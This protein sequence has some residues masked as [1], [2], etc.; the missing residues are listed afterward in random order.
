MRQ[1]LFDLTGRTALVTGAS[2]G[3]GREIALALA[4]AGAG[5]VLAA[6]RQDRLEEV[7]RQIE[8]SGGRADALVVDLSDPA[9]IEQM[10]ARCANAL[11]A[12]DILVNAAGVNPRTPVAQLDLQTWHDTLHI[13]L[14]VPF[15]LARSLTTAMCERG[16][17][18]IINLASLQSL[19]AFPDGLPYGTAKGG[20]VQMT[21]AMAQ[22]WSRFGVNCNAIGPGFFPTE[23]TT[24]VFADAEL[25]RHHAERTMIG[26]NGQLADLHGI[27]IFLAAPASDYITGQTIFVDGG[28]TAQ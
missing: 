28:Y 15:L 21:R 26:R 10:P 12:P 23:L 27:T 3:I 5:V 6:R 19:R 9:A 2:S 25:S 24:P 11:G 16:W 14:T 20:V 4:S 22:A 8:D 13:H 18:R 7:R 1:D 17:G